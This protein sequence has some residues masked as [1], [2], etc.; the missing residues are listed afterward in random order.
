[1]S[2]P[3]D[4]K[5]TPTDG[6]IVEKLGVLSGRWPFSL[7]IDGQVYYDIRK[8]LPDKMIDDINPLNS[9]SNY[10]EDLLYRKKND[11]VRSQIEK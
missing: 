6:E 7:K 2:A 1:M 8:D 4:K 11:L 3:F 9:N 5:P 10:R